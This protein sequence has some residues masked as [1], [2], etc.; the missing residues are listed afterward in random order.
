MTTLV[1]PGSAARAEGARKVASDSELRE[2]AAAGAGFI[3]D[4]FN[5]RWH[6]AACPRVAVMTVGQ[7]KWHVG[8]AA[9]REA[10]LEQRLAR[11][12]AAQPVL[13]CPSCGEDAP[14]PR[15]LPGILSPSAGSGAGA[16]LRDPCMRRSASGFGVWADEYVRNDSAAG[17]SAGLLRRVIVGEIRSL[18]APAGRVLHASYGGQRRPGTDVENLLFNNID[19]TLALFGGPG[20]AG[21]RFE[22]LGPAVPPAPDGTPRHSCYR[23]CLA[24]RGAGFTAVQ[25]GPLICRIPEIPVLDGPA[26][27]A[28]RIWLAARR[29]R[30]QPAGVPAEHGS[31]LL[32]VIVHQLDPAQSIKAI[33]DGVTAAMQ[34][35]D[36]GRVTE[37]VSRLSVL[38]NADPDELLALATAPGAPLGTRSRPGPASRQSLFTLDSS[39]Q[40]RVTPDDDRCIAAEVTTTVNHGP[41]RLSAEVYTATRG[42]DGTGK[43][44][45]AQPP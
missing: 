8:T 37:A 19:Q 17:S 13:P 12:P 36:P 25:Q 32:K 7:A 39:A 31:F 22:D 21:I 43:A 35:D 18:P 28:A 16:Q 45:Q 10:F 30:P 26:R 23:Y 14:G 11:Y 3:I 33:I 5:R 6:A 4:P 41:T 24:P 15:A 34:R 20:S 44:G 40:V 42:P 9:A 1:R 29:A 2:I 38:L 27:L